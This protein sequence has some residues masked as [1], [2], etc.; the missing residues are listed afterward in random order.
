MG[1]AL[2]SVLSLV[3]A[4]VPSAVLT[5]PPPTL[6]AP[7]GYYPVGVRYVDLVDSSR[8]NSVLTG[9]HS[10]R[11]IMVKLFYPGINDPQKPYLKYANGSEELIGQYAVL[12]GV[13]KTTLNFLTAADTHSKENLAVS[14]V[15]RNYPVILFSHGLGVSMEMQTQQAEDL[16][17]RGYVVAD[18]DATYLSFATELPSGIVK[19][20]IT[21]AGPFDVLQKWTGVMAADQAYVLDVLTQLNSGQSIPGARWLTNGSWAPA[22]GAN[23]LAGKLNLDQVGSIG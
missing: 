22:A 1:K 16:A 18:I 17:S 11:E 14:G 8:D 6:L 3:S 2:V 9:D 15:L 10:A 12:Q 19:T 23:Q 13:P 7:S 4:V 20:P 5:L 21:A